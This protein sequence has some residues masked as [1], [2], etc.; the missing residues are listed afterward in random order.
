MIQ[1]T[2]HWDHWESQKNDGF[3]AFAKENCLWGTT[4]NS[5]SATEMDGF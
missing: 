5:A 4:F 2:W 1:Q 3:L